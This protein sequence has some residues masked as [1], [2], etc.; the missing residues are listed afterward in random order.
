MLRHAHESRAD[1][2]R[3]ARGPA[4]ADDM[5]ARAHA[6]S[7][8]ALLLLAII[9]NGEDIDCLKD[10]LYAD[11]DTECREY[12]RC[13]AGAVKRRYTC[14]AGRA[15]SEVAGAC[16]PQRRQ[17]CT[18]RVC[19]A[20]DSLAYATPGTACRQYYR[21]DNGTV[22]DHACP[23]GLW[24][25]LERQAC[26]RGAGTCYE[27]VCTGLPDGEYPD[28]SHECRR[29]LR[30]RGGD[31][32]AVVTCGGACS[33]GCPPPRAT[34]AALPA[35]DADFCSDAVCSSLCQR[36]PDGAYADRQTGCR[37]YFVCEAGRV[38]R[39]GV[40]EF[41]LLFA[42]SGCEHA[43]RASCPPPARSP[44][45]NRPDGLHRDWRDCSSWMEC[46]RERVVSRGSCVRGQ[47]FDG[48]R[49]A[50]RGA[51]YCRGPEFA[52]SCAGM[53][54]GLY[55][56]LES[57]CTQYYH[58]VG[59]QRTSLACPRGEVYDGVQCA[60]AHQYLCPSL[61]KDS[62]YRRADGRYRTSDAGCRGYYVCAGGT[63]AVYACP[64]GSAFDGD[65]CVPAR[66][67]VCPLED[68]SCSGLPNGYHAELESN[69]HRYFYCSGG[70]RLAT[71]S[72][73]G[74]KIFDG[75]AC[76]EP[77]EHECGA[78][79]RGEAGGGY[80]ERDGFFA[81]RGTACRSYYFCVS[82][83]RTALTCP[84]GQLFNGAICV[85]ADQYSCPG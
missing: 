34:A 29:R 42:D 22:V 24:F 25:D 73:L 53:P 39:R 37:E 40:C 72:C 19:A 20:G 64:A 43:A 79:R 60:P 69:C 45:F 5:G 51:F 50:P 27:P 4:V 23:P 66:P 71:L 68:Y 2:E 31:I 46:R 67:D 7:L 74:D 47:V 3:A 48:E 15:F 85:P 54:T 1:G 75:R 61:E 8:S 44:C 13:A 33:I 41:G 10:G 76:V 70:D 35:G 28:S 65:R 18:R 56:D 80:C 57:N 38:V 32:E 84:G 81:Q 16:V 14:P 55:Q 59:G 11:Y 83:S 49:C 82:G 6:R 26:T 17:T 58:C 21:C 9:A 12:V 62:C 78:P 36:K 30:C 77:T 52:E 63:R